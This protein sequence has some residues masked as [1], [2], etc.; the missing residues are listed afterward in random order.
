M[1]TLVPYSFVA[2]GI[3]FDP[4][5]TFFIPRGSITLDWNASWNTV[6]GPFGTNNFVGNQWKYGNKLFTDHCDVLFINVPD[7]GAPIKS[8]DSVWRNFIATPI[9]TYGNPFSA[10]TDGP[11]SAATPP[12]GFYT[13]S[14]PGPALPPNVFGGTLWNPYPGVSYFGG[15]AGGGTL[16]Y[17]LGSPATNQLG[18]SAAH[19]ACHGVFNLPDNG[20]I[21]SFPADMTSILW[22]SEGPCPTPNAAD[23]ALFQKIYGA[24]KTNSQLLGPSALLGVI[25]SCYMGAKGTPPDNAGLVYWYNLGAS[26]L[27]SLCANLMTASSPNFPNSPT[28]AAFVSEVYLRVLGRAPDPSGAAFWLSNPSN[29]AVLLGIASSTEAAIGSPVYGT[30]GRVGA[31]PNGSPLWFS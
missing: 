13:P 10:S 19:E 28:S 3:G 24:P 21:S 31:F 17:L 14:G 16:G 7:S 29:A 27:P 6:L 20:G 4:T 2:G 25:Y 9:E 12:F 15:P 22:P 26:A 1:T 5:A 18:W 11:G 8:L 23:I 30:T